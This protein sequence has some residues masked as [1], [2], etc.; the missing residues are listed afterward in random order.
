M[1][2]GLKL[3]RR[4]PKM[5]FFVLVVLS[6]AYLLRVLAINASLL[7]FN[8]WQSHAEKSAVTI[9]DGKPYCII[10]L[11]PNIGWYVPSRFS[12]LNIKTVIEKEVHWKFNHFDFR[13]GEQSRTQR[14][15]EVHFGILFNKKLYYWSFMKQGFFD[16]RANGYS[17]DFYKRMKQTKEFVR[18]GELIKD[19]LPEVDL[20]EGV[21]TYGAQS[22]R[23]SKSADNSVDRKQARQASEQAYFKQSYARW[24]QRL[25]EKQ[26]PLTPDDFVC[27]YI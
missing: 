8:D 16:A 10:N 14:L 24:L 9:T 21:I 26:P 4:F 18:K 2:Y 15:R 25:N 11:M 13:L 19:E 1:R 12:Q 6:Y 22:S 27:P 23:R 7:Y 17:D 5:S 3:V 20:L